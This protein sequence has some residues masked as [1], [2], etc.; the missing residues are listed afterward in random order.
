MSE[1]KLL[2]DFRQGAEY[3]LTVTKKVGDN[4]E[5]LEA[6]YRADPSITSEL[7][8]EDASSAVGLFRERRQTI[9]EAENE[10]L[11]RCLSDLLLCELHPHLCETDAVVLIKGPP[12]PKLIGR[13]GYRFP[14]RGVTIAFVTVDARYFSAPRQP[15]AVP[16]RNSDW[17]GPFP[18]E[19]EES[20]T[21]CFY[22]RSEPRLRVDFFTQ[23]LNGTVADPKGES[24]R[25]GLAEMLSRH[26]EII[27]RFA[28][29]LLLDSGRAGV[30]RLPMAGEL[31]ARVGNLFEEPELQPRVREAAR[32]GGREQ[33]RQS[34]TVR[35]QTIKSD[36]ADEEAFRA[37]VGEL[38]SQTAKRLFRDLG[39]L[40]QH[41]HLGPLGNNLPFLRFVRKKRDANKHPRSW[42]LSQWYEEF[43]SEKNAFG[44]TSA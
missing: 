43:Q 20:L 25:P 22:S 34:P 33:P 3:K 21:R 23:A 32:A 36:L 29:S 28:Q 38:H 12:L 35:P 24:V 4:Q 41:D 17:D 10:R 5:L 2:Y 27:K 11:E 14:R 16:E 40:A 37:I 26:A 13:I 7:R 30:R 1:V 8:V 15:P 19:Q 6:S 42:N 31:P 39:S 18:G 9:S 44:G